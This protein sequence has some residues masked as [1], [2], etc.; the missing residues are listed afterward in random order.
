MLEFTVDR[1]NYL[2]GK[3][4]LGFAIETNSTIHRRG[5]NDNSVTYYSKPVI[6]DIAA[7][8]FLKKSTN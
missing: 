5:E 1:F 7:K 6:N 4:P 2:K 8:N 3:G